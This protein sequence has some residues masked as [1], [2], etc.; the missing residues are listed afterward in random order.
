MESPFAA[1]MDRFALEHPDSTPAKDTPDA[2]LTTLTDKGY[3]HEAQIEAEFEAQGY[4]VTRISGAANEEK[5][6][7]TLAAMREGA[8]VITQARLEL[9]PL[10]G[11][12]DFLVKVPGASQ[13]GDY[14]Y[15]V[16][17]AKL[18]NSAK[19]TFVIQLCCYA[20]MLNAMQGR[21][22][23]TITLAL[24]SGERQ[25]L[26]TADFYAYYQSLKNTYLNEQ[27]NFDP[28][29]PPDPADSKSW[30]DWSTYAEQLLL[31][32]DHLF[33]VANISRG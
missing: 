9:A 27:N 7:Q 24:G 2:L 14:H 5:L 10:A 19:P 23:Q 33:Q 25:A 13:L 21:L 8:D 30:G 15:E 12:A 11:Y 6:A 26:R 16:W 4:H 31:S 3:A 20:E 18:A 22:P 17:D 29:Q 28:D 1:W 32:R